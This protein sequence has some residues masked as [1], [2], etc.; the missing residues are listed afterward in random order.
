MTARTYL[1][2]VFVAAFTVPA[3][4][5]DDDTADAGTDAAAE[6]DAGSDAEG[7][8]PGAGSTTTT[9]P[10]YAGYTSDVY[11]AADKW[12]C[13]PDLPSDTCRE[14]LDVTVVNTD[15]TTEVVRHTIAAS[16][17]VDCF[18][19]YPTLN[20]G[21]EGN[22]TFDGPAT[23]LE[24]G[25]THAQAGAFSSVC[26]VFAPRYRQLTLGGFSTG[27]RELAYGDVV[28]SFKHYMANDNDGRGV[29]LMGHSQ[30]SGHLTRLLQE[31]FDDD[32][33]M[34]ARLVSALII[35][36]GVAVPRGEDVGGDLANIPACRDEDETGCVISYASFRST[37]PPPENSFF[38][39]VRE[40]NGQVLCTN[41]AALGGGAAELDLR[42]PGTAAAFAPGVEANPITTGFIAMPGLLT[43]ECVE[44]DGFTYLEITVNGDPSDPRT[45]TIG[46][47]L[48]PEW[49]LHS[50]DISLALGDLVDDVRTQI[51]SFA[52]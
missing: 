45:D 42:F 28:D 35:G 10:A 7:G 18:Y 16:P 33:A 11:G 24:I 40:G 52:G 27:D 32:P 20:F 51:E 50:V 34:R 41:P 22:T 9:E 39:R 13:R 48:T 2:L 1:L 31:E 30:G 47:D 6:T 29:V 46:G 36:S 37:A 25:T 14:N 8:P 3:C 21:D 19:V 43:G 4:S 49:G 44:R 12:I 38:G 15:G 26:R 5:G 23:D 17:A